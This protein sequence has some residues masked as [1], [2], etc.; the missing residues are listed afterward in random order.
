MLT[1][2]SLSLISMS[3]VPRFASMVCVLRCKADKE[4]PLKGK[5]WKL[6][7]RMMDFAGGN[8]IRRLG[9]GTKVVDGVVK[10]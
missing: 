9:G 2:L 7:G 5:M 8:G 1:G 10:S 3:F 4:C 6:F